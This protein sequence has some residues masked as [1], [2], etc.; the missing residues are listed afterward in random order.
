MNKMV[1]SAKLESEHIELRLH[2]GTEFGDF[3]VTLGTAIA[4]MRGIQGGFSNITP[5]A[6]Q[7]FGQISDLMVCHARIWSNT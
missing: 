3:A 7:L 5:Q 4:A 2:T 1:D 6:D